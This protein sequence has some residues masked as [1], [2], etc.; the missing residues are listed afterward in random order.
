MCNV[1]AESNYAFVCEVEILF[2]DFEFDPSADL[3]HST[4]VEN[5]PDHILIIDDD[6]TQVT[7]LSHSLMT[8]GYRISVAGNR[9]D[10]VRLALSDRPD[11]ILLDIKLPDGNG[12]DICSE[13]N[14]DPETA[15]VPVI[16]V[17]G[18]DRPN[19]V[20]KARASGCH[21]FVHKP[22]DPNALLILA[23]NAIAESRDW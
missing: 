22:F 1:S 2:D 7:T 21:Y 19:V 16:I 20:R 15:D 4:V 12:L 3:S 10:G 6:E 13:F 11:L 23:Q 8:L 18:D 9:S 14:D 5:P 17:S